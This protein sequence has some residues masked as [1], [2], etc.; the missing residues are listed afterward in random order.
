MS[1]S[2]WLIV[3]VNI[4][5]MFAVILIGWVARHRNYLTAETTSSLSRF[6][7]DIT[8]PAMVLTSML[9]TVDPAKLAVSW[10]LPLIGGGILLAG[11]L[12]GLATMPF[13]SRKDQRA[14]FIFL[15]AVANWIYLPLPIAQQ[16]YGDD[17]VRAVLLLNVGATVVLWTVGIGTLQRGALNLATL[18]N[19]LMNPGLLA[20]A[21]GILLA[22][23]V[24]KY[25]LADVPLATVPAG[26]LAVKTLLNAL[27]LVGSLTIPLSLVVTG[28][29]LGGLDISDHRPSRTLTGVILSRLFIAPAAMVAITCGL[30]LLGIHFDEV[31]RMVAYIIACMPVAVSCSMFTERFGGDTSLAARSIFYTTLVSILSVPALFYLIQRLG[32]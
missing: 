29:Q 31:T 27:T 3:L 20:T 2:K 17:G 28:A 10:Y 32:L 8:I 11:Q 23:F 1:D 18:R 30:R 26:M 7:V 19:L 6:V 13:F 12:V 25:L 5:A 4:A 16:L 14:T 24:P 9:R 22:L 21:A 15:V